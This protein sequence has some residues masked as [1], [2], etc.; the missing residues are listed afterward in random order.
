M[1]LLGSLESI[2]S[3][4]ELM[5]SKPTGGLTKWFREDWRD[6]KTGKKCG[7]SGKDDKGRPYPACRPAS[8]SKSA[9]AKKAA[10]RKTSKKRISWKT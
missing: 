8:Q 4:V 9:S 5:P 7:R 3:A 1:V 6:V 10:K 2:K